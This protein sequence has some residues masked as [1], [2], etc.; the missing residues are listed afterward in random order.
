MYFETASKS[1]VE[2]TVS[3]LSWKLWSTNLNFWCTTSFFEHAISVRG[4]ISGALLPFRTCCFHYRLHRFP[5]GLE[6]LSDECEFAC[7][8]LQKVYLQKLAFPP[9]SFLFLCSLFAHSIY[10][11]LLSASQSISI[12]LRSILVNSLL[13]CLQIS[14]RSHD[15]Q[16]DPVRNS[17]YLGHA[18]GEH[19]TQVCHMFGIDQGEVGRG[20]ADACLVSEGKRST[21]LSHHARLSSELLIYMRQ[22]T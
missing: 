17:F 1:S 16:R 18:R 22:P 21:V 2:S 3:L 19:G 14:L 20:V 4:W 15:S 12:N 13:Q 10:T 6:S 5:I 9:M 7:R 8:N 11:A